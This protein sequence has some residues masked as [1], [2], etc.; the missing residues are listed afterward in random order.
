MAAANTVGD[1]ACSLSASGTPDYSLVPAGVA[2]A[3]GVAG[4]YT[5]MIW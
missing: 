4:N 1:P 2:V 3:V 5:C